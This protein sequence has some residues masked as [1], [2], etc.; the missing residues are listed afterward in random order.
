MKQYPEAKL[1][2]KWLLITQSNFRIIVFK[3]CANKFCKNLSKEQ[4][5]QIS[6]P[7]DFLTFLIKRR[8]S[9][10]WFKQYQKR[11]CI[12]PEILKAYLRH[13]L[14]CIRINSF[15]LVQKR[16]PFYQIWASSTLKK[17]S[18]NKECGILFHSHVFVLHNIVPL[19]I[20]FDFSSH[21]F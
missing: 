2:E 19:N 21:L 5:N 7:T 18:Y 17:N 8:P 10:L 9:Y 4:C 14:K 6:F 11:Q 16:L 13:I 1:Y 20:P 3:F 15:C 12:L